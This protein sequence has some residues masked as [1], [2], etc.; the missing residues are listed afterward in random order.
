MLKIL[1][2]VIALSQLVLA[3]FTLFLPLTFFGLMGLSVPA[4]DNGYM[5]GML[6]ARFLAYGLGMIM[7]ARM[8]RPSRFWLANM[9]LIQI[10][11]FALG[12]AYLALGRIPLSVAG[13]PMTNAAIFALG[14]G[15]ALWPRRKTAALA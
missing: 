2:Y 1:L 8:P 4:P 15:L 12:G 10:I 5:I 14:L 13:F 9:A 6:G 3:G 7:L 11:D